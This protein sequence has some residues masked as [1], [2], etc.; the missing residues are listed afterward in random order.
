M[1][2]ATK[3]PETVVGLHFFNPAHLNILVE[4]IYTNTTDKT[5]LNTVVQIAKQISKTPV[6]VGN[7][8]GFCGNRM[9]HSYFAEVS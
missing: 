2:N 7:A 1:A 6:I 8:P 3:R 5:A 4:V 9:S